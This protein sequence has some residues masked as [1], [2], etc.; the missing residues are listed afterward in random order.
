MK[1]VTPGKY[2]LPTIFVVQAK[3][4]QSV[5]H[6][7]ESWFKGTVEEKVAGQVKVHDNRM[8]KWLCYGRGTARRAC[9]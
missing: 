2:T 1:V 9:Q 4:I 7:L 3:Q 8:N 6:D 5:Y